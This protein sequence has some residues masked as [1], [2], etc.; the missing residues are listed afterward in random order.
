MRELLNKHS[1]EFK[2]VSDADFPKIRFDLAR[3]DLDVVWKE[4]TFK[5]FKDQT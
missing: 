4:E 2:V 3:Q 1:I 5:Y